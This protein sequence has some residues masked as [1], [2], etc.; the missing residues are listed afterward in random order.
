MIKALSKNLRGFTIAETLIAIGIVVIVVLSVVA[1]ATFSLRFTATEKIHTIAQDVSR[2]VMSQHVR[3]I[4]FDELNSYIPDGETNVRKVLYDK[5]NH[6][7]E[8]STSSLLS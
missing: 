5:K 8:L 7:N 4:Q 1:T 3:T 2:N 6:I